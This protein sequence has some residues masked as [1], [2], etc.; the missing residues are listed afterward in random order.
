MKIEKN[1]KHKTRIIIAV[2]LIAVA[3]VAA[4]L[5]VYSKYFYVN[6]TNQTNSPTNSVN[7]D[8]ATKEQLDAGTNIKNNVSDGSGTDQVADPTP[9]EGSTKKNVQVTFTA[10]SQSETT[11]QIRARIDAIENTGI[12]TLTLTSEGQSTVTR[13]ANTQSLASISTCKGFDVPLSELPA[14]IWQALISYDSATL[15]GSATKTITIN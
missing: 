5:F 6:K 11:I 4:G 8:E 12:C 9:I 13:T 10:V 7:Y 15:I 1:K 3:L 14:G 2:S